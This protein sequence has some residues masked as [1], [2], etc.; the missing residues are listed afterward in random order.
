MHRTLSKAFGAEREVWEAARMLFR[1]DEINGKPTVIVQSKIR[2]DWSYLNVL[3]GYLAEYPAVKDYDPLIHPG[4]V[5]RF[6]LRANPTKKIA[7]VDAEGNITSARVGLFG[8]EKQMGW[9]RRKAGEN[10]FE[11]I[12][13]KCEIVAIGN[14]DSKKSGI[15]GKIRHLGVTFEGILRVTEPEKFKRALA[16]GIG[17]AKGFGFGLLSVAPVGK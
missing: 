12:E 13:D 5:L 11:L 9:L 7:K 8:E 15:S 2:P 17:S 4:Q 6:R 1:V 14:F 3:D 10:G 16:N